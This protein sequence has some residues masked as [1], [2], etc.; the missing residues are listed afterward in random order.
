M[1]RGE[2]D[3][4][5]DLFSSLTE[6]PQWTIQARATDDEQ[7]L[8]QLDQQ[9]HTIQ[10]NLHDGQMRAWNSDKRFVF[11]IAGT[12]GGKTSFLPW[13]EARARL[14]DAAGDS[15]MV[16][17]SYDLFKLKF[18]PEVLNVFEHI[19]EI[20]R[21][22]LSDR[23]IELRDP[24]TGK[25]WA[26]RSQDKMYGRIIL[27]SA[28]AGGG[29]ESAT[30]KR[31][32]LDEFG[33]DEFSLTAWEAV[34]RRLSLNRGRVFGATT[35]Y[36]LGWVKQ[37]IYDP[38]EK[39]QSPDTDIIQFP[40]TLNPAFSN[41]EFTSIREQMPKWRFQ[42]FYEGIFTRPA[43]QI[44]HDFIDQY[45]DEGGHKVRRF[46]VPI[47]WARYVGVDP[48][49]VNTAKL[50][51]AHDPLE[52]VYYIYREALGKRKSALEHAREMIDLAQ[53]NNERVVR[54]A[55]G[56]KS[57]KY[58]REDFTA[59]GAR[60]VV[61]PDSPNVEEGIDRV[62]RLLK[63]HRLYFFDDLDGVLDEIARYAR[64][65]DANGEITDKI[66]DKSTFHLLDALRYLCMSIIGK[67]RKPLT[68]NTK[69]VL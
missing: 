24:E 44:Y 64:E 26:N 47:E 12:Q 35:P 13:L 41:E 7:P 56:A 62:I 8:Y 17:S 51:A 2:M 45:K 59:A 14:I 60:G 18:L 32:I 66:K 48:G 29:L 55:V 50:W 19:L 43:G 46:Q 67:Q 61:E 6:R 49:V 1:T 40:S 63:Q 33:Q 16:T 27:R 15:L 5:R 57:E 10:L 54:W 4:A 69:R 20:G 42:M 36:N 34:R 25:Y 53:K 21:Y 11:M 58:W 23:V 9:E 37:K 22:W 52:D 31:A 38:W 28:S 39:K 3:F 30:A 65:L 68:V